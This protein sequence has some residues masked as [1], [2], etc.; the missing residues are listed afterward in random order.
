MQRILEFLIQI[1]NKDLDT[2]VPELSQAVSDCPANL[3]A[4][5]SP[6]TT[7][8]PDLSNWKGNSDAIY[9]GSSV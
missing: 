8:D 6:N 3:P 2:T 5:Y 1:N 7:S 9:W 4:D